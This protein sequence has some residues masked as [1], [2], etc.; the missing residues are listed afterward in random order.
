[1]TIEFIDQDISTP[2]GWRG[3]LSH[4]QKCLHAQASEGEL[5]GA[6]VTLVITADPATGKRLDRPAIAVVGTIF[7]GGSE[8]EIEL[9]K[10]AFAFV[11]ADLPLPKGQEF[12]A[13]EIFDGISMSM[14]RGFEI[15]DRSEPCRI[16]VLYGHKCL[17]PE[18]A[19]RIHNDG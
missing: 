16:D 11:T 15:A 4:I 17:Y 8:D 9:N 1:M 7:T 19:V 6:D 14:V 18:L 12:A 13:R 2:A 5:R 10:D 3:F